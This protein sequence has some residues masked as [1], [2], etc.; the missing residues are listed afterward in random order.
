MGNQLM[1]ES[2]RYKKTS[3]A[4]TFVTCAVSFQLRGACQAKSSMHVTLYGHDITV[5]FNIANLASRELGDL[6]FL[7]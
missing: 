1:I 5:G 3:N 6:P 4:V 2:D 7:W